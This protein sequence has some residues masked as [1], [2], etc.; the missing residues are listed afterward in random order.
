MSANVEIAWIS[1]DVDDKF[2]SSFQTS[3]LADVL[4]IIA[5]DPTNVKFEDIGYLIKIRTDDLDRANQ[6]PWNAIVGPKFA[7]A[8]SFDAGGF[9]NFEVFDSSPNPAYPNGRTICHVLMWRSSDPFD[10]VTMIDDHTVE[11]TVPPQ[12]QPGEKLTIKLPGGKVVVCRIPD[13]LKEGDKFPV[14]I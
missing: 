3:V 1:A 6:R 2:L 11:A 9:M 7:G 10:P 8:V 14:R 4:A 13:G 5:S 12:S